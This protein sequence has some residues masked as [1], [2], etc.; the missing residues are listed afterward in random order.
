VVVKVRVKDLQ[1]EG[2]DVTDGYGRKH[3]EPPQGGVVWTTQG[4][5]TTVNHDVF[6]HVTQF[7]KDTV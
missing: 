4:G 3:S 7:K 1:P 6:Y 2:I 5:E